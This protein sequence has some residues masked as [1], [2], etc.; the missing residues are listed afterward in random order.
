MT[1][2]STTGAEAAIVA[3][4]RERREALIETTAALVEVDT[5]N[6]NGTSSDFDRIQRM[7]AAR[8]RELGASTDLWVP[9]PI[10]PDPR[11]LPTGLDFEGR[12]QLAASLPGSGGGHSLLLTGHVDV[13]PTGRTEDWSSPPLS[14][15]LKEGCLHGR[16]VADM[17]G[18]IASILIALETLR[19]LGMKLRGD[20]VFCSVTDEETTGMGSRAAVLRGVR[21]DAG[22]CPEP[23]SF[24]VCPGCRGAV[25]L[26]VE[27]T[28]RSGHAMSRV[29]WREGGGKSAV[30]LTPALI[31][32]VKRLRRSWAERPGQAHPF[33]GPAQAAATMVH[34]GVSSATCAPTCTITLRLAY[35][36]HQADWQGMCSTAEHE[37][38][39]AL[40]SA[41]QGDQWLSEHP[42]RWQ[43]AYDVP[44]YEVDPDH[45]LIAMLLGASACADRGAK[46]IAPY[47]WSDAA[48][49]SN[50]GTPTVLYG[51]DDA[52][53]IHSPRERIVV[54]ELVDHCAALAVAI[55]RWCGTE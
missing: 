6:D 9:E 40:E 2:S 29:P 11:W 47:F 54:D 48:H 13:V 43:R 24:A 8:L 17:K 55:V 18:G 3:A 44:P 46:V 28:G 52:G 33:L 10:P 7:L 45:P 27:C 30:E 1:R 16:G 42:L 20:V 15:T 22:I 5:T 21:A 32:A 36:P 37:L 26:T 23:T 51:V 41:T 50:A 12:P 38:I 19:A 35:L 53:T 39:E 14:A 25:D 4:V 31:E 49:F 34:G